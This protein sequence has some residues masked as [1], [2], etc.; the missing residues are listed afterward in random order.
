MSSDT[1]PISIALGSGDTTWDLGPEGDD[2]PR[3]NE[4]GR[5]L[6]A[7]MWRSGNALGIADQAVVSATS[8]LSTIVVGRVCGASE[9]G[10][11]TLAVSILV[12]IN[13]LQNSLIAAPY[14]LRGAHLPA[15]AEKHFASNVLIHMVLLFSLISL[16]MA[17][18]VYGSWVSGL[19]PVEGRVA[20]IVVVVA[21][22]LFAMR[23]L[24]RRFAFAHLHVS[25]ALAIDLLVAAVQLTSIGVLAYLNRLTAVTGLT[26][27]AA[28]NA[29][30]SLGWLAAASRW[31]APVL[32]DLA[33]DWRENWSLSKWLAASDLTSVFGSYFI[34]WLLAAMLGSLETGIYSACMTVILLANP[35]LLGLQNV[36]QPRVARALAE[37]G[38][39]QMRPV[40]HRATGL[41]V[42]F[43]LAFCLVAAVA[44]GKFVELLYQGQEY[45][46]Q[47]TLVAILAG[48]ALVESAG[49]AACC[50]LRAMGQ[51]NLVFMAGIIDLVAAL[52]LAVLLIPTWG[53]IGAAVAMLISSIVGTVLR[54][55]AFQYSR[56]KLEPPSMRIFSPVKSSQK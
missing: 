2:S 55:V 51:T 41:Y 36:L 23:Q 43:M 7:R 12:T 14:T 53:L 28:A 6:L 25:T 10:I 18:L 38:E 13:A 11:F 33:V 1:D 42:V 48:M 47:N 37:G 24:A 19:L 46:A 5:G 52:L 20:A 31:F 17:G 40:V 49:V 50:G 27:L 21:T 15:A 22:P 54:L 35:V 16:I 56:S 32:S 39:A 3:G 8:F 45:A 29:V 9:L 26:S 4:P 44:G 34:F 30:V